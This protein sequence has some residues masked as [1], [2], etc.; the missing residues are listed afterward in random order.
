MN[1]LWAKHLL[2]TQNDHLGIDEKNYRLHTLVINYLSEL[3]KLPG[4]IH[5]YSISIKTNPSKELEA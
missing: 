1:F 4:G 2:Q 5:Y 3:E